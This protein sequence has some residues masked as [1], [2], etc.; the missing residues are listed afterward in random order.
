MNH[1]VV[2]TF[3]GPDRPGLVEGLSAAVSRAEGNWLE[4]RMSQLAGQ[5]AGI[6]RVALAEENE[7]KLAE[8]LAGLHETGL[9][10]TI[11]NP[12]EASDVEGSEATLSII[13]QD[14]P[15]IVSEVSRALAAQHINVM[16]MRSEITSA[17]MSGE[18]LFEA[19]ALIHLPEGVSN[20][21]LVDELEEIANQL[22]VD[23]Q[24]GE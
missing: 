10:I 6:V 15:G 22:N 21:Q 2:F 16:E 20:D 7:E 9:F 18:P 12:V 19:Q 14:R 13:G 24:L 8:A 5:F 1:T 23:I 3:I 11:Q 17:A 4:S